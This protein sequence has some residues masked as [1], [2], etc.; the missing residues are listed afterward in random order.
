MLRSLAAFYRQRWPNC[1]HFT[2]LLSDALMDGGEP[3]QAV[4]LLHEIA[5]QDVSGQVA[6]RLWGENHPYRNLWPEDLSINLDIPIPVSIAA[7]LGWNRLPEHAS[8][9]EEAQPAASNGGNQK[10]GG[11]NC[12]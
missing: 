7:A 10:I 1:Q 2:L 8:I 12:E 5:A 6:S 4:A 9:M 11:D 3:D